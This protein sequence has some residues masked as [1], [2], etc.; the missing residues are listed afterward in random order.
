M[1]PLE[2]QELLEKHNRWTAG[3]P[4]GT[5][6]DFS[7]R[8]LSG[9]HLEG[10]NLKGAKLTGAQ[11]SEA[12]LS[13]VNFFEADLFAADLRNADLKGANLGSADLRGAQMRGADLSDANLFKADLRD[14]TLISRGDEG[15]PQVDHSQCICCCKCTKTCGVF[16]FI[17]CDGPAVR[18]DG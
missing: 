4:G 15:P 16:V 5:R 6:A 13:K 18:I 10:A 3:A 9:I 2:L 17:A 14:G 8:P 11:M 12:K 7:L 1:H